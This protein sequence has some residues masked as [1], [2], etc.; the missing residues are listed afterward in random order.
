MDK[1]EKGDIGVGLGP[2]LVTA[3]SIHP[4]LLKRLVAT[5]RTHGIP[6]QR[7]AMSR[8][9]GTDA[10]AFAYA[11]AGIPTALMCVPLKYMHTT[12]EAAN[13]QDIAASVELLYHFIQSLDLAELEADGLFG[14][15]YSANTA[16][17]PAGKA[18]LH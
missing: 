4:L 9:T 16:A 15:S 18:E 6:F 10:D 2:V 14:S 5:A 3:P 17:T 13:R 11:G 7:L 8:S 12:V 1:Q